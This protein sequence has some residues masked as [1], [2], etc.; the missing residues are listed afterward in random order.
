MNNS[1]RSLDFRDSFRS[2]IGKIKQFGIR[3][4]R[5]GLVCV[6]GVGLALRLYHLSDKG[7]WYDEADSIY[8]AQQSIGF[9][10]EFLSYKPVYFFLLKIWASGFGYGPGGVRFFS[11]LVSTAAMFIVYRLGKKIFGSGTGLIAGFLLAISCFSVFQAQ[12]ARHFS[13]MELLS[14]CSFL[15]FIKA[16]QAPGQAAFLAVF[17]MNLLI[18][19]IHPYGNAVPLSQILLLAFLPRARDKKKTLFLLVLPVILSALVLVSAGRNALE[20]VWWVPAPDARSLG[21]F[22]ATLNYGGTSYGLQNFTI[23]REMLGLTISPNL[24]FGGLFAAGVFSSLKTGNEREKNFRCQT[25]GTFL[26]LAWFFVPVALAFLFSFLKPV[27]VIKHLL[28]TAIPYY[29]IV[30]KGI[31]AFRSLLWRGMLMA[32][33]TAFSIQPLW[34]M[35]HHDFQHDWKNISSH[36]KKQVKQDSL[37]VIGSNMEMLP[38]F[39]Y[40]RG[41]DFLKNLR[42]VD[43]PEDQNTVSIEKPRMFFV[44]LRENQKHSELFFVKD[45]EVSM[46]EVRR[47]P[48]KPEDVWVITSRWTDPRAFSFLK[49]YFKARSFKVDHETVFK[50]VQCARLSRR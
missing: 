24:V 6:V 16:L 33:I 5:F 15:M 42:I 34:T 12:Q 23:P 9:F 30:A 41:P 20:M 26:C 18:V 37:I 22:F 21:E 11:V 7:I 36:L 19:F 13:L 35:H 39:Y 32:A 29:L 40:F 1:G 8:C 46:Q 43:G 47:L 38:F 17:C 4:E 44:G 2:L 45:F 28:F 25:A 27:F 3:P 31:I 10:G 14:A 50:G 49:D 48:W